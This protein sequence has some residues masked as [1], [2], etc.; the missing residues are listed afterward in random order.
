MFKPFSD[1]ENDGFRS[2][3]KAQE[4]RYVLPSRKQLSE[5]ALEQTRHKVQQKGK[6]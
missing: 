2:L 5:A 4:P 1:V 6:I 3:I